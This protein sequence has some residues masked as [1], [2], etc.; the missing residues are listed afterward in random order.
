MR[1][2]GT[3]KTPT[4]TVTAQRF[5]RVMQALSEQL[6]DAD[7][8]RSAELMA[9]AKG[10][11]DTYNERFAETSDTLAFIR[12]YLRLLGNGEFHTVEKELRTNDFEGKK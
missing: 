1:G 2:D 9:H 3:Q 12:R 4:P 5:T 8:T 6:D 10:Q 11:D 7:A